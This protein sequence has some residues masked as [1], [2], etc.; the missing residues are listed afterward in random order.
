MLSVG[1]LGVFRIVG[2]DNNNWAELGPAGRG[3]ASFLFTYPGRPHRREHLADLFWPTLDYEHARRALNSAVWRLRRLLAQYSQS[4]GGQNL[5]TIGCET[6][7]DQAPWLDIDAAALL[8]ASNLVKKQP[9]ALHD[10]EVLNRVTTVLQRYQGPFL[11]GDEGDWI[12]DEREH[13]HSLFLRTTTVVVCRLGATE[14]YD[15]AI[16]LTRRALRFDPYR[17]ELVRTLLILLALDERRVEAIQF[18]HNWS[19]SLKNEI[20]IAPLPA[21]RKLID[22]IRGLQSHD[23]FQALKSK[24]AN[25]R[26][27]P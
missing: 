18:Y 7:L 12:L 3:L 4:A 23:S 11:D 27:N 13:L 8:E 26:I 24:L 17:E 9:A 15:E 22:E 5:K 2:I 6:L 19:K 10:Q 14:T 20:E 16:R 1:L 21:T 25:L